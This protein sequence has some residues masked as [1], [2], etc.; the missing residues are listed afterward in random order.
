VHRRSAGQANLFDFS[1]AS[2]TKG[3]ADLRN[4]SPLGAEPKARWDGEAA[5]RAQSM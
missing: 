3:A 1:A 2:L 5:D 4:Q